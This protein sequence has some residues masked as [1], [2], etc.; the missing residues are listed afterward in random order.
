MSRYQQFVDLCCGNLI[1]ENVSGHLLFDNA[2]AHR[3]IELLN[4]DQ[5][6]FRRLPKYS[7][8]LNPVE[9]AISC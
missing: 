6:S 2:P 8:I 1:A 4:M 3:D 9:N 5:I 7:P